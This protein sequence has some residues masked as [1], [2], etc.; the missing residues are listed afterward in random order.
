MDFVIQLIQLL[1]TT[2]LSLLK[3]SFLRSKP[4]N[5][6]RQ[7]IKLAPTTIENTLDVVSEKVRKEQ[8][9]RT[10]ALR[11]CFCRCSSSAPE[12]EPAGAAAERGETGAAT[13]GYRSES[14]DF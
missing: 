4:R 7:L 10:R 3:F 2:N 13:G 1:L 14:S 6:S 9:R 8:V 11:R 12:E 5:L